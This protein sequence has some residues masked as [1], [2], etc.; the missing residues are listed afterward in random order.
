MTLKTAVFAP[1]PS[2]STITAMA[3]NPGERN[4]ERTA[5]GEGQKSMEKNVGWFTGGGFYSSRSARSG[6]IRAALLAGS[7]LASI[8]TP[9]SSSATA[10]SVAGSVGL[11]P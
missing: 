11:M 2:P 7:Q 10:A 1:M 4:R 9:P 8:D 5:R 3:V 6:S